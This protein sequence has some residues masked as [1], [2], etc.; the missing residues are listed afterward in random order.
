MSVKA[1]PKSSAQM[2]PRVAAR[3]QELAH[4]RM[5]KRRR[6]VLVVLLVMA[7]AA[8][9]V[10]VWFTPLFDVDRVLVRG[11]AVLSSDA[12]RRASGITNG[13]PMALIRPGDAERRVDRLPYVAS[14]RVTR[15][16]PGTVIIEVRERVGV[17]WAPRAD[18]AP[19]V[20]DGTGRVLAL[21][22]AP[23]TDL[24]RIEGLS[25]I[26]DPGRRVSDS[27]A[28]GVLPQLPPGLRSLVATVVTDAN[29]VTLRLVD[30]LDVLLG[31]PDDIAAKGAV[32]EAVIARAPAGTRVVDVR[33]PTSPVTR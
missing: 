29:G 26:P 23:P 16:L 7:L 10:G 28:L 21:P 14:T 24:P 13:E 5:R 6:L 8:I 4:G 33:V 20:L 11:N 19:A 22:E 17:A 15:D 2:D 31:D 3:R 30:A 12:I 27:S 32:A 1:S 18:G 25:N 9:A